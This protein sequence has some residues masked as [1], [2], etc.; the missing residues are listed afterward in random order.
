MG[1]HHQQP[2]PVVKTDTQTQRH[3]ALEPSPSVA[4]TTGPLSD[5]LSSGSLNGMSSSLN[6]SL[7]SMSFVELLN[8]GEQEDLFL[9]DDLAMAVTAQPPHLNLNAS[10]ASCEH[11]IT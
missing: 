9:S 11:D 3:T 5:S 1:H 7:S 2:I 8:R 10:E 4:T 6:S